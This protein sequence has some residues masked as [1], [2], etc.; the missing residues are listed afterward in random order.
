MRAVIA[1]GV[2]LALAGVARANGRYP[3]SNQLVIMPGSPSTLVVRTTFGLLLTRDRSSFDCVCETGIGYGADGGVEDPAIA[4]S[5]GGSLFVGLQRGLA[6]SKDTGCG[7]SFAGGALAGAT[8]TD[9]TMVRSAPN[10]VIAMTST[11][12]DGGAAPYA[13]QLHLSTDDGASFVPYGMPIDSSVL[14]LTVDVAP[15][16]SH[17]VYVTGERS[18][19]GSA[20][21]FVSTDDAQT[22]IERPIALTGSE[23]GAYIIA[24]DPKNADRLYIRTY[25]ASST[26]LLV[27]DDAGKTFTTRFSGGKST[28]GLAA[29]LSADG[30]KVFIG[31]DFD[32]LKVASTSDFVFSQVSFL[33]PQCLAIEG[34]RLYACLRDS[35]NTFL[36]VSENGGQTFSP[37]L[38]RCGV[39]GPIACA[40]DA[41][42]SVCA[43]EWAPI[44]T[45]LGVPCPPPSDAGPSDGGIP[46]DGGTTVTPSKGCGC[47]TMEGGAPGAVAFLIAIVMAALGK[48][49]TVNRRQ[50]TGDVERKR[51]KR[52]EDGSDR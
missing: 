37:V 5:A 52:G 13:S 22:W 25:D 35:T 19:L 18:F 30:S 16:N 39:R 51:Q 24:I 27:T 17:Q 44:A 7:W 43:S 50:A 15:S 8:V 42:A 14:T 36:V 45:T 47:A 32:G 3:A 33:Q 10:S 4:A 38:R 28:D 23:A 48:R 2:V 9:V 41:S 26:R 12:G 46:P 29:A 31:T 34:A 49:T 1:L 21:L 40:P 6:V 20:S 11:A